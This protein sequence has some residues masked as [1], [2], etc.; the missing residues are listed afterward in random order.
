MR[1]LM[2]HSLGTGA[3]MISLFKGSL[4]PG[5][6]DRQE[7]AEKKRRKGLINGRWHRLISG[8]RSGSQFDVDVL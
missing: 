2:S 1:A 6:S 7:L 5:Q 4:K 3:Q 8:R